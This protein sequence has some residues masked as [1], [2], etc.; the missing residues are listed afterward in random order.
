MT[1]PNSKVAK[2]KITVKRT[3]IRSGPL[4]PTSISYSAKLTMID[5]YGFIRR[6]EKDFGI[7]SFKKLEQ[8]L[9]EL[10]QS[11]IKEGLTEDK[12]MINMGL[13]A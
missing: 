7:I 8:K 3:Q 9:E 2:V 4:F 1:E 13:N 6:L 12:I 11:F 5:E 10:K